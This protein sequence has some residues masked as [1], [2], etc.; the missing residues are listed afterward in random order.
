MSSNVGDGG[1]R[2]I[3]ADGDTR[4]T[5]R[6]A[7]DGLSPS[8]NRRGVKLLNDEARIVATAAA[9]ALVSFLEPAARR[10]V[11]ALARPS[12]DSSTVAGIFQRASDRGSKEE[13]RTGAPG[14]AVGR[15][16]AAPKAAAVRIAFMA[17]NAV[18]V[19]LRHNELAAF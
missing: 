15:R 17:A 13:R 10:P 6:E 8:A 11:A 19:S 16:T 1:A 18:A 9:A 2:E 3:T 14:E 7:Y 5:R 12:S 4:E